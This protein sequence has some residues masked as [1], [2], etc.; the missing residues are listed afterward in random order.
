MIVDMVFYIR[1]I[2]SDLIFK[3]EVIGAI[4]LM[5]MPART[6]F[7]GPPCGTPRLAHGPCTSTLAMPTGTTSGVTLVF[8][9][10]QSDH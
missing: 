7:I 8:P 5:T 9:F 4:L 6:G 3:Q 10:A 2:S 1:L